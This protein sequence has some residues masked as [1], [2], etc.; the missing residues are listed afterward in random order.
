MLSVASPLSSV[1]PAVSGRAQV[2]SASEHNRTVVPASGEPPG[3]PATVLPPLPQEV[4][5]AM[6]LTSI[7][8]GAVAGKSHFACPRQAQ[9]AGKHWAAQLVARHVSTACC[10]RATRLLPA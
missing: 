8:W 10:S 6:G 2:G 4:Q 5:T 9:G 3:P 7:V 1:V